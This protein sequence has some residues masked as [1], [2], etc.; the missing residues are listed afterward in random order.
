MSSEDSVNYIHYWSHDDKYY[1]SLLKYSLEHYRENKYKIIKA[2]EASGFTYDS[3]PSM[4]AIM[5]KD[6]EPQDTNTIDFL[7]AHY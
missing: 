2:F 3:C 1:A 7:G 5:P 6:Y 4:I